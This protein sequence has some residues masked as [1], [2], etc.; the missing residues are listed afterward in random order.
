MG[1]PVPVLV[2]NGVPAPFD[3]S[4]IPAGYP[5]RRGEGGEN[6]E[7][8]NCSEDSTLLVCKR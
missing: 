7:V 6:D 3:L 1:E 2:A 4:P 8:Q 5:A